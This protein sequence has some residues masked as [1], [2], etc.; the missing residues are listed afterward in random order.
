MEIGRVIK[1]F[2]R[3]IWVGGT[4]FLIDLGLLLL[5]VELGI[6]YIVSNSASFLIAN[7]F[8][9]IAGHYFVFNKRARFD[10]L[11]RSYIAVL[12]ISVLGLLLNDAVLFVGVEIIR[13]PIVPSK[14]L[15]TITVLLWNF[16]ARKR[17]VY[18]T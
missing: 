14:I 2:H 15:A 10:N 4:A 12:G 16:A 11:F 5:L 13:L 7:A 3:Y 9:F 18:T 17:L 6:H 8:N 1:E